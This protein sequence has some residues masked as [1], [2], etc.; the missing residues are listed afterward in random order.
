M[1]SRA[2]F[3]LLGLTLIFLYQETTA[4]EKIQCSVSYSAMGE[5]IQV[6]GPFEGSSIAGS[7]LSFVNH[8]AV[9]GVYKSARLIDANLDIQL[10]DAKSTGGYP[11]VVLKAHPSNHYPLP[12][13]VILGLWKVKDYYELALVHAKS[14]TLEASDALT[15]DLIRGAMKDMFDKNRSEDFYAWTRVRGYATTFLDASIH[16]P[17]LPEI[18]DIRVICYP[19]ALNPFEAEA[20]WFEEALKDAQKTLR[21]QQK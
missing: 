13:R 4:A 2:F 9:R 7:S 14:E 17:V 12:G 21:E 20:R 10:D 18:R 15:K 19:P 1:R 3:S 8:P 16:T 11:L 5:V 6:H